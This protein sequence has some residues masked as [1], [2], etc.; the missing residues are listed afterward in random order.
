MQKANALDFMDY[1]ERF[2]FKQQHNIIKQQEVVSILEVYEVS[3][4]L[5]YVLRKLKFESE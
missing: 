5:Q 4:T 3:F 1:G 2:Y